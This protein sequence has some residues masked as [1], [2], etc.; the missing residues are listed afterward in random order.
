MSRFE[1]FKQTY[2]CKNADWHQSSCSYSR[3]A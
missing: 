1:E 2:A 3:H